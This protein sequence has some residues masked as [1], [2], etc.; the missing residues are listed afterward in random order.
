MGDEIRKVSR[1]PSGPLYDPAQELAA[2]EQGA[3]AEVDAADVCATPIEEI[4]DRELAKLGTQ[5]GYLLDA[6]RKGWNAAVQNVAPPAGREGVLTALEALH[7]I[8]FNANPDIIKEAVGEAV[9]A[10]RSQPIPVPGVHE[11]PPLQ[12]EN[13]RKAWSSGYRDGRKH[14]EQQRKPD[15]SKAFNDGYELAMKQVNE[16][17]IAQEAPKPVATS[18]GQSADF[19]EGYRQGLIS[20]EK[21]GRHAQACEDD[22]IFGALTREDYYRKQREI[23]DRQLQKADPLP[24]WA[25]GPPTSGREKLAADHAAQLDRH[26]H[27][28]DGLDSRID[29]AESNHR[30]MREDVEGLAQ[31][32]DKLRKDHDEH[33]VE[34]AKFA[35]RNQTLAQ[36]AHNAARSA[37]DGLAE[38]E[39]RADVQKAHWERVEN[40]TDDLKRDVDRLRT[41]VGGAAGRAETAV[42]VAREARRLASNPGGDAGV[43]A[44][45]ADALTVEPPH[46]PRKP[47]W[48]D[49]QDRNPD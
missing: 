3:Q 12:T 6:W 43:P 10:L 17:G 16:Q 24:S 23:G 45:P 8:D 47:V 14:G 38:L 27:E 37:S 41:E 48:P 42:E 1:D 25:V 49:P 40:R 4:R 36:A 28:I 35:G 22:R 2:Y 5:P 26:S 31:C 20:G 34:Y 18:C 19:D 15:E 39:K 7:G 13:E 32:F 21:M 11:P 29:Q 44:P 46:D 30:A 9:T 33:V